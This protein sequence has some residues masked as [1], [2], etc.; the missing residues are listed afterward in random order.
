[1]KIYSEKAK[2]NL[3]K[4]QSDNFPK[5]MNTDSKNGKPNKKK[6][7]MA[8]R[9][10]HIPRDYFNVKPSELN[11]ISFIPHMPKINL[12]NDTFRSE[13]FKSEFYNNLDSF[14]HHNT[15]ITNN[16]NINIFYNNIIKENLVKN[17]K[18]QNNLNLLIPSTKEKHKIK[19]K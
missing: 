3:P 19:T 12:K 10:F 16:N 18:S 4:Q 2:G 7:I 5:K 14:T 13:K 15:N 11:C 1:M 8:N 9:S 17:N 6:R